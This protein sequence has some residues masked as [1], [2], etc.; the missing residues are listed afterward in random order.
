MIITINLLDKSV[1]CILYNAQQKKRKAWHQY[2]T[3]A[4]LGLSYA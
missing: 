3:A 1:L 2:F 4:E